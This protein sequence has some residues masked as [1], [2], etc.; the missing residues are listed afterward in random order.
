MASDDPYSQ[1]IKS[2]LK[3]KKDPG[4]S[5]ASKRSSS[6]RGIDQITG[7]Q[8]AG[9][10]VQGTASSAGS[11]SQSLETTR[12]VDNPGETASDTATPG[13]DGDEHLTPAEKAFRLA[14]R[15]REKD[16]IGK[17]LHLTH[18]QRMEKLNAHL[19]TLSEHFDIPKVGPG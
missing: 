13:N 11:A 8:A 18:R 19:A 3:L 10:N 6:K 12:A 15:T 17:R 14:Y 2:G 1:V 4:A 5:N 7:G 16:R 9:G